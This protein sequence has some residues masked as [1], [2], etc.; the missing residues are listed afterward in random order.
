MSSDEGEPTSPVLPRD[1]DRGSSVSSEL[2]V[3]THWTSCSK[4]KSHKTW[5]FYET[6]HTDRHLWRLVSVLLVVWQ[7]EYEELLRYAVVTP[8]F[9]AHAG[10][11]LQ[12]LS[13]SHVSADG[14][15]GNDDAR[16]LRPAGIT[17]CYTRTHTTQTH[18]HTT[19]SH[20]HSSSHTP[21]SLRHSHRHTAWG[22]P[23]I[24]AI[25]WSTAIRDLA[26]ECLHHVFSK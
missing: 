3:Q 15:S 7:D 14:R 10:A 1:S 21:I 26:S 12:L 25:K 22:L 20:T 4:D 11:Q 16:S 2:Q 18:T 24:A 6:H 17:G 8:R 23:N 13:T 5:W 19:H 9:E